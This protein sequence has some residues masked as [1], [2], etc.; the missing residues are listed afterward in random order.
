MTTLLLLAL[1]TAPKPAPTAVP[2]PLPT[3]PAAL[4]SRRALRQARLIVQ[5]EMLQLRNQRLDC[6]RAV[7]LRRLPEAL[8]PQEPTTSAAQAKRLSPSPRCS[9]LLNY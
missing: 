7:L 3:S 8:R 4:F 5:M 2:S 9:E 6:I 1:L